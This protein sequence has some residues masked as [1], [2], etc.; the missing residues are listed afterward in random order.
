MTRV[1][2]VPE[3]VHSEASQIAALRRSQAGH[4]V[5]DAWR[6]YMTNHR[7]EFASDL[8]QA[9]KLLRDGTLDD[10]ARFASRNAS[11]RAARAVERLNG[12]RTKPSR[13]TQSSTPDQAA[14][15]TVL[16]ETLDELAS[17]GWHYTPTRTARAVEDLN[18]TELRRVMGYLRTVGL[19]EDQPLEADQNSKSSQAASR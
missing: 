3:Q 9:A 18:P 12:Q 16:Q 19:L 14:S 10:L 15:T 8:E 4:V 17:F 6:E 11:S 1:L 5:A 7:E 2:R 13:S